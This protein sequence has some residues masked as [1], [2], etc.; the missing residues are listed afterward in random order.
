MGRCELYLPNSLQCIS[1]QNVEC[2]SEWLYGLLIKLS[3]LDHPVTC[4]MWD[5]VFQS[6]E[7]SN[8][9]DSHIHISDM[10][11]K[12]C[13]SGMSNIK[14]LVVNGNIGLFEL[15]RETSTRILS[16]RTAEC[17]SLASAILHTLNRLTKLF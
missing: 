14:T 17:A 10:R 12:L 1:L 15:L 16:L 3:S 2:S 11:S 6:T 5:V 13:S 8:E 7:I 4:M 9:D